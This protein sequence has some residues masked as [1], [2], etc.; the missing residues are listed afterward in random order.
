[1]TS[2][3]V[4]ATPSA[5]TMEKGLGDHVQFTSGAVDGTAR[6]RSTSAGSSS[7]RSCED[8]RSDSNSMAGFARLPDSVGPR[9]C[10]SPATYDVTATSQ[11]PAYD[12][13]V[14]LVVRNTFIDTDVWR[15]SSLCDFL[16]QRQVRSCPASVIGESVGL[17]ELEEAT[18]WP[19]HQAVVE[20]VEIPAETVTA[21]TLEASM[22][23]EVSTTVSELRSF[24]ATGAIEVCGSQHGFVTHQSPAS[25][26]LPSQAPVLDSMPQLPETTATLGPPVLWLAD[27]LPWPQLGSPA[28]PTVG[29]ASH[30][31]GVCRPWKIQGP[32][33]M[34][35]VLSLFFRSPQKGMRRAAQIGGQ[36]MW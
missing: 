17:E 36:Y 22:E 35:E 19:S 29:S 27:S 34:Q 28:L 11:L 32:P 10:D 30:Q 26:P 5:L 12:Y 14:P 23:Q 1:M 2:M 6:S 20:N 3:I 33:P 15:P 24:R 21:A 18:Y 31:L 4:G 9:L 13:P 16:Q 25:P 8:A 7:A